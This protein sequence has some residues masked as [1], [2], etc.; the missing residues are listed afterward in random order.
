MSETR[1]RCIDDAM[2]LAY[3]EGGLDDESRRR[4]DEHLQLHP[5][6]SERISAFDR[7]LDFMKTAMSDAVVPFPDSAAIRRRARGMIVRR[8]TIRYAA[9]AAVMLMVAAPFVLN[10]NDNPVA[11]APMANA[12]ESLDMDYLKAAVAQLEYETEVIRAMNR[13][14]E[15]VTPGLEL[16]YARIEDGLLPHSAEE[17]SASILLCAAKY[18]TNRDAELSEARYRDLATFFP[19]P[20][21]AAEA[22]D[23]G[24]FSNQS[25]TL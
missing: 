18:W 20:F 19:G 7:D 23:H 4:V 6:D 11:P 15:R 21:A 2:L 24:G 17:E 22:K 1:M 16:M 9:V 12:D 8:T 10:Q 14:S 13:R 5:E 25:S 3:H